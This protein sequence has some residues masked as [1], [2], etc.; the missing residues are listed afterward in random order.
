MENVLQFKYVLTCQGE[1]NYALE[2]YARIAPDLLFLD[3][4]LPDV[5][6]HELLEKI[7]RIDP[8]VYVIMLSWNADKQNIS[9]AMQKGAKGYLAKPFLPDK[10]FQYI[11]R[12]RTLKP[13]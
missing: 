1:A 6:G 3:I 7:M 11:E 9:Q 13:S 12:C 4:N 8:D 5:T 10:L 2:T